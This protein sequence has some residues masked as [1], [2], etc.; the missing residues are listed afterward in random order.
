MKADAEMASA[1]FTR[2]WVAGSVGDT[3]QFLLSGTS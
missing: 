1:F 2:S 3:A